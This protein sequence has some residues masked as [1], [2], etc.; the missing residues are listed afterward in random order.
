M[1]WLVCLVS[2]FG[3][4]DRSK[5]SALKANLH[6]MHGAACRFYM[7][8]GRYPT[9]A[10]GLQ[11][12]LERPPIW[13]ERKPWVF[14][15]ETMPRDHWNREFVYVL[16]PTPNRRFGFYSLGADGVSASRGNDHD[17]INS[18]NAQRPWHSHYKARGIRYQEPYARKPPWTVLAL[19]AAAAWIVA[20]FLLHSARK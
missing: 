2:A 17:D 6:L 8:Y 15:L 1:V 7:T 10:E 14:I 3:I 16:D 12:L 13:T 18:W 5:V 9:E 11:V 4:V 19:I 20:C